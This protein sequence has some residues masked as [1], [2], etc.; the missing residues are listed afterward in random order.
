[1][2]RRYFSAQL[3]EE[4]MKKTSMIVFG[5]VAQTFL[6]VGGRAAADT[7]VFADATGSVINS[8]V[9]VAGT[10]YNADWYLP[11]GTPQ[12][13]MLLQHGFSRGCGNLRNTSINIM[14]QGVMLLCLNAS[15][16]GGNP[17]LGA[18]LGDL[19]ANR[20]LTPPNGK[21]LPLRYIVGGHSAGGHFASAV[22]KRLVERGYAQF[23]GAVLA[24][25]VAAGGFTDNLNAISAGGSRPVLAITANASACNS[26]NNANGALRGLG[27][28]FVGVQLTRL[29][30]HNDV[31]GG[32]GDIVAQLACGFPQ[33]INIGYMQVLSA[34]WARDLAY[35]TYTA[36][37]Y[38][39]GSYL[40]T[41]ISQGRAK[42]IK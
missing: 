15:M 13:F 17:S 22:G 25:P 37:Y 26:L 21:P 40:Q 27:N 8:Q 30:T 14:R 12:G 41:L 24:D 5:I 11:S 42:K 2:S 18:A 9:A 23:A 4:L 28:P 39:G 35:G 34:A 7:I 38:P 32:N 33:S 29:S 36:T 20:S 6:L 10:S 16:S 19:M 31:E 1:M 3:R